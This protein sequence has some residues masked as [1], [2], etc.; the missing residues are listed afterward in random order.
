MS[1]SPKPKSRI[2]EHCCYCRRSVDEVGGLPGMKW[3]S[4]D[5]KERWCTDES[6]CKAQMRRN[7]FRIIDGGRVGGRP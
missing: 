7:K 2:P 4:P 1:E 6:D 3:V 5:F